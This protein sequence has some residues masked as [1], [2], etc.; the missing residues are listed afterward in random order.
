MTGL[1]KVK[2]PEELMDL[3]KRNYFL[4]MNGKKPI[5]LC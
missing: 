4:E 1:G 5:R 2:K 3:A